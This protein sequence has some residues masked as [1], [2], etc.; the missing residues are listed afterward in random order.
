MV[1]FKKSPVSK[2]HRSVAPINAEDVEKEWEDEK[3]AQES[4]L[5]DLLDWTMTPKTQLLDEGHACC[6]IATPQT[7]E[8]QHKHFIAREMEIFPSRL[9]KKTLSGLIS[10]CSPNALQI[11]VREED[12]RRCGGDVALLKD[13]ALPNFDNPNKKA[14]Q[15]ASKVRKQAMAS[16][17]TPPKERFPPSSVFGH[18]AGESLSSFLGSRPISAPTGDQSASSQ[19]LPRLKTEED[20]AKRAK[21]VRKSSSV[22]SLL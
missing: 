11:R 2:S 20:M 22:P 7:S 19:N 16:S 5:D 1:K 9:C 6:F 17:L 21:I 14:T 12:L 3:E 13:R 10:P 4:D 15:S 8:R 18:P